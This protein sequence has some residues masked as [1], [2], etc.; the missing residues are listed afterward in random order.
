MEADWEFEAGGDAP[1]IEANCAGFVDL[2]RAPE[3]IWELREA[4]EFPDLAET[5]LRLNAGSSPVWSSKCDLWLEL[6][7]GEFDAGEL[8]APPGCS[9]H[10]AGCYIDLL[11]RSMERWA[12]PVLV[13]TDCR[14]LCARFHA[15][16]LRSCR[17]DLVIRNATFA[18]ERS[19][20]GITAYL[21]ACGASSSEAAERLRT[22]LRVLAD[23]LCGH[24]G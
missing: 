3:R 13:E 2:R 11:P 23:V 10:A 21:T 18:P 7:S 19:G 15:I 8:D 9:A 4:A 5:L 14:D 22:A 20:L 6:S 17:A 1:V 12:L 16:P 24:A